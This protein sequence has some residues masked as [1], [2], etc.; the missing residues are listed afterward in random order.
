MNMR[1]CLCVVCVCVCW[2]GGGRAQQPQHRHTPRPH[3]LLMCSDS[4]C[5]L[6]RSAS[7]SGSVTSWLALSESH[8]SAVAPHRPAGRLLR[9]LKCRLRCATCVGWWVVGGG[10]VWRVSMGACHAST[11]DVTRARHAATHR[12][13]RQLTCER[14][15]SSSGSAAMLLLC[16]SSR[17]RALSAPMQGGTHASLFSDRSLRAGAR[18]R[19][20]QRGAV[21]D[22]ARGPLQHS[23][24]CCAKQRRRCCLQRRQACVD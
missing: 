13:Q 22:G 15:P 4:R 17:L 10:R 8:T 11:H 14:R 7:S 9:A 1:V 12:P 23:A 2:G 16:R 18:V 6:L 21:S 20:T 3:T 24:A 5:R 19:S